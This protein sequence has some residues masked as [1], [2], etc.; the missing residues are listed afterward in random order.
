MR[1]WSFDRIPQSGDCFVVDCSLNG[2][3]ACKSARI[4]FVIVYS[5]DGP[6]MRE[7]F[8][9]QIKK[10]NEKRNTA[11]TA[12]VLLPPFSKRL[13]ELASFELYESAGAI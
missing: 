8:V 12:C 7:M 5:A 2:P 9:R 13:N 3:S 6:P 11:M 4:S 1:V 10:P